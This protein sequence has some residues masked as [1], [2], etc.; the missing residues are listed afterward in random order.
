VLLHAL[1]VLVWL[2]RLGGRQLL[3]ERPDAAMPHS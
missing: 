1:A 2:E 3:A